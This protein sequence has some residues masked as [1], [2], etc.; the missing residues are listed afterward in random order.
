VGEERPRE[1]P[2][3]APPALQTVSLSGPR[4][5]VTFLSDGIVNQLATE[6][7]V[8]AS[9]VVSQFGWQFEKRLVASRSGLTLVTEWI[10]LVGGA[11]QGLVLPSA[12]WLIGLRTRKGIELGVGPN[13]TPAGFAL[14][15]AAGV[16][17]RSGGLNFPVNVAVVPSEHGVRVS[18]L[19]GANWR[20]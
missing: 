5:G 19:C 16:T 1:T 12:T 2:L 18:L 15:L 20:R 13:A 3:E 11:E 8:H 9:P 14:A 6:W 10:L 17:F 7:E 4:L